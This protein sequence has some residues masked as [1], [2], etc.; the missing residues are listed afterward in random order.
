MIAHQSQLTMEMPVI[1]SQKKKY[2]HLEAVTKCTYQSAINLA[3]TTQKN[4]SFLI[5]G[6][7]HNAIDTIIHF[8]H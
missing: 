4:A 8:I 3:D 5:I 6:W 1:F 7:M 2:I